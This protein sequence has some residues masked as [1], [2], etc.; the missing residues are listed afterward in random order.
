LAIGPPQRVGLVRP[1]D[2]AQARLALAL[3]PGVHAV[4]EGARAAGRRGDGP[5]RVLRIGAEDLGEQAEAAV[6]EVFGHVLHLDRV[7]QVRLVAAV[8]GHRLGVGQA[9]E[10]L[11][12]QRVAEIV[13]EDVLAIDRRDRLA[14]RELLEHAVHD[15][16]DGREHV[17][18]RHEAHLDVELVEFQRPVGAQVLIAEARGDLEIAVEAR[19]HQQ[20]LELLRGLRQRVELARVQTR[21]HQE[22]ARAFRRLEAVRIGVWYSRKP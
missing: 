2:I 14:V 17:F 16:L 7:A 10:A 21:R 19:D 9:L 5:H 11:V 22:V 1:E 12:L 15:R 4:A 8:P 20:L 18:L 3:G 13:G 6:A